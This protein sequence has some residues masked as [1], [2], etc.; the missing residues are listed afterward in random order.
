VISADVQ[1]THFHRA[2]QDSN[3]LFY[4]AFRVLPAL[5]FFAGANST[6]LV[7]Q[8]QA[9]VDSFVQAQSAVSISGVLANI[10]TDG[11]KAQGVPAG[12]VVASPSRSDPDCKLINCNAGNFF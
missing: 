4:S 3:M 10:G 12:I 2:A 6:P 5:L 11:S 8:R 9:S 7:S 1:G